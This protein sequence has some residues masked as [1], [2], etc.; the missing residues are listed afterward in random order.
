MGGAFSLTHIAVVVLVLVL[1]FGANR[2]PELMRSLGSG[3]KEFKGGMQEPKTEDF[4][5]L[6]RIDPELK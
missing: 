3:V 4:P 1:L 6:P 5:S 2:I